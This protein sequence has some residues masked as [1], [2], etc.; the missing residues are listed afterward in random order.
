[1]MTAPT[2]D[3]ICR[4]AAVATVGKKLVYLILVVWIGG[5]APL[6]YFNVFA[7]DHYLP[8]Y[9]IAGLSQPPKLHAI[10]PGQFSA[11]INSQ[12]WQKFIAHT[13]TIAT[14]SRLPSVAQLFQQSTDL[15]C[16]QQGDALPVVSLYLGRLCLCETPVDCSTTLPPPK[17]PPRWL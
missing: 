14:A 12:L 5:I 2:N 9:Q 8:P 3:K 13:D 1:M 4:G 15:P 10:F 7:V 17:K 11:R 6:T 16:L